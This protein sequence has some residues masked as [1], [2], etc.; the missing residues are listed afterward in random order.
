MAHDI[1]SLDAIALRDRIAAGGLSASEVTEAYCARIAAE[2][3]Q[4]RAWAWHD[5]DFARAQAAQMD[6]HRAT[7]RPLG[8]LHGVPVGLKDVI[9]TARIPTENGCALD[10]GRVPAKDAFVVE[11]LKAEG[12][13]I[14]GKT[15][16][17]PLQFL[18][19]GPTRNPHA[20]DHTPGG[21]SSGSAAAVAA[22]MVPLAIGT[23]T[24]GSVIRPASFCGI[25]GYKP[26]FGA[27]PRT[28]VLEQSKSLDTL[29][30]FARTPSDAALLADV[31]IGYDPG[32]PATTPGPAPQL[33]TNA[34]SEPP[35]PPVFAFIKPPEWD[36][37]D[38]ELKDALAELID[39]LGV[40]VFEAPLPSAFDEAARQRAIINSAEMAK[41]YYAYG[42]HRDHLGAKTVAA[43]TDGEAIPARDYLAALDWKPVLY[44]G[45]EEVFARC[46]AVLTPAALGPAP[47]GLESTGD[48]I[49]NGLWTLLGTPAVTL[50]L[51]S[52]SNGLPMG[53]QLVGP[54]GGDGRLLRTAQWLWQ[55]L[56]SGAEE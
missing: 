32:D 39:H 4:V 38:P 25:T 9:D 53:V 29:G 16:T 28:G 44:A 41:A 21:S 49:F 11:R 15:V 31:L 36:R 13:V 40:Q 24:G 46:D 17:T 54:R 45:L 23:Q 7:G 12:A 18:D 27:I 5:P 10:A 3:P 50:P 42:K 47:A 34:T 56:G 33:L 26:T 8:A 51:L 22:A 14:L 37:A 43:L 2:D 55:S 1:L 20:L 30:V 52:A 6:R 19:P 48:A 35:L